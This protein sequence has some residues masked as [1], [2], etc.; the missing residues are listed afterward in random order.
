MY[1]L[2]GRI[3]FVHKWFFNWLYQLFKWYIFSCWSGFMHKLFGGL[4]SRL[5]RFI[6]LQN[7]L[8]WYILS[9]WGFIMLCLH[10]WYIRAK[11]WYV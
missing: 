4:V 1:Q 3:I 10:R 7:L 2:R 11:F 5:H 6:E 9:D 8:F